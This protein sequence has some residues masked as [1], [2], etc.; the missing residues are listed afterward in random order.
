MNYIHSEITGLI[1][2]AFFNVYNE[3]GYGFLEKVYER[4]MVLELEHLDLEVEEQKRITVFYKDEKVGDYFADLIINDQVIIEL[5]AVE[6]IAPEHE[7]QLVNYLKATNI[8][9]GLLLNF[10]AKPQYKRKVF[11]KNYHI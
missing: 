4:A 2:K 11:T 6:R 5:K 9:V 10:G 7:V 8:E 3:L 1:L